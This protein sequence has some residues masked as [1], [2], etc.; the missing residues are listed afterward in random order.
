MIPKTH[1]TREV[2]RESDRYVYNNDTGTY[3]RILDILISDSGDN[4]VNTLHYNHLFD[5]AFTGAVNQLITQRLGSPFSED[6]L[7]KKWNTINNTPEIS[8][9]LVIS[10]TNGNVMINYAGHE[11]QSVYIIEL[12]KSL[13]QNIDDQLQVS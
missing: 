10:V 1:A 6:V 5:P 9:E 3:T 12:L 13:I 8:G 2:M 7:E 4:P 11:E